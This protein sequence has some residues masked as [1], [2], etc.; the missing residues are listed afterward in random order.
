M[1][2]MSKLVS[3]CVI[4]FGFVK[5][6]QAHTLS[7]SYCFSPCFMLYHLRRIKINTQTQ[8]NLQLQCKYYCLLL[9]CPVFIYSW[10][11]TGA[12]FLQDVCHKTRTKTKTR[13]YWFETGF[14]I[15][16]KS[17]TTSLVFSYPR[18]ICF[19]RHDDHDIRNWPWYFED[20]SAFQ[21]EVFRVR[22]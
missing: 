20:V 2:V 8:N 7:I 9:T 17:Q 10:K 1:K 12:N 15:R 11:T 22:L 6:S 14:V 4:L 13:F 18:L 3:S 21:N 5:L 16:P 19:C